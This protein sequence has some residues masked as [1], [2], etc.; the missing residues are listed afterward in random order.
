[1]CKAGFAGDDAPRA[2]FR[3]SFSPSLAQRLAPLVPCQDAARS[4][5]NLLANLDIYAQRPLSVVPVIMGKLSMFL[6]AWTDRSH[7]HFCIC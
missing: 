2:V 6:S 3:K 4:V 7:S 5:M 1:M